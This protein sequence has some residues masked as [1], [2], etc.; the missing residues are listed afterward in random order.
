[1]SP[2]S[3]TP[4]LT[5]LA[6]LLQELREE[7]GLSYGELSEVSGVPKTTLFRL[8]RGDNRTAHVSTLN[9][10][11]LALNCDVEALYRAAGLA[12]AS[13]LLPELPVY[14]RTKYNLDDAAIQKLSETLKQLTETP[15][16][17]TSSAKS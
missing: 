4:G 1:M 5:P 11:A 6:R 13:E 7:L 12:G 17:P 9:K 16:S 2:N 10:L 14:F 15:D 3:S 8:E